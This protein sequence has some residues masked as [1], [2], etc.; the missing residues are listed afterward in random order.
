MRHSI[1]APPNPLGTS[2]DLRAHLDQVLT[3]LRVRPRCGSMSAQFAPR[4]R[5]AAPATHRRDQVRVR[6][7]VHARKLLRRLF[8]DDPVEL[9][10]RRFRQNRVASLLLGDQGPPS[11]SDLRP[12][13]GQH[14]ETASTGLCKTPAGCVMTARLTSRVGE[15]RGPGYRANA[16]TSCTQPPPRMSS[17]VPG[18]IDQHAA[19]VVCG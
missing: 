3:V 19:F 4:R 6:A 9:H 16:S 13:R 2:A 15:A 11:G 1:E 14:R 8:D 7:A 18:L 10:V 17:T 12:A 5:R